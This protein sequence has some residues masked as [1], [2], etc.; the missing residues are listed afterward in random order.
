[1]TRR[2]LKNVV[3]VDSNV[4][5]AAVHMH[6]YGRYVKLTDVTTGE[7]LWHSDVEYLPGRMQISSIASYS[8]TQGFAMY[9]DHEY[10]LEAL[11][12]NTSDGDIDAMAVM[13]LYFSPVNGELLEIGQNKRGR[14]GL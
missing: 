14:K 8:S 11:Y 2:I 4:H 9:P 7:V 1:M 13:Y 6:N 12:D 5:F 10:E 3:P